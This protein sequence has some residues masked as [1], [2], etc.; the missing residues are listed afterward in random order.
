MELLVDEARELA[1]SGVKELTVIAQDT[2]GYGMDIYGRSMLAPLLKKLAK[3]D[4]LDWIR[5]LYTYP[6]TV[7]EEL[8]DVIAGEKKLLNYIDMPIQHISDRLLRAMNRRGDS[9]HI[10]R[11]LGYIRAAANDFIIRTTLIVGFPGE[12]EQEF[13]QLTDFLL[14]YELDRV[15]AFAY[16]AE[17]GTAAAEFCSQIDEDTKRARLD[18]LMG[19]QQVIS[20]DLNARRTG[21]TYDVLLTGKEDGW[22]YGR[23]YAEAPEVDGAVKF[24]LKGGA[25]NVGDFYR[26]LITEAGAYDL[27][28]EQV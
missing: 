10:K 8:I 2:S 20:R 11:M 19:T 22:G 16:S 25:H 7:N 4:E 5:L 9:T 3:I 28:G 26:V 14:E 21:K 13:G 17:D 1:G 24:R 6:D 23:T 12:T 15:G 18:T 27:K